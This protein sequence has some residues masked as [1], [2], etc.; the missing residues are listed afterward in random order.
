MASFVLNFH[1]SP[2]PLK[3]WSCGAGFGSL[4]SHRCF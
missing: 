4:S 2:D 1:D 3:V